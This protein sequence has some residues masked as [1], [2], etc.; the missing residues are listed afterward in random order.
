MADRPDQEKGPQLVA[1]PATVPTEDRGKYSIEMY[2]DSKRSSLAH[3]VNACVVSIMRH[4]G[5]LGELGGE[6][7]FLCQGTD[8]FEEMIDKEGRTLITRQRVGKLSGCGK[9]IPPE[10]VDGPLAVCPHCERVWERGKLADV[11]A[12]KSTPQALAEF[13]ADIYRRGCNSDA[14]L[15]IYYNPG[16]PRL[17]AMAGGAEFD[18]HR[19]SRKPAIYPQGHIRN[20]LL[21]GADIVKRVRAFITG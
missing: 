8:D 18:A 2:F 5:D 9:L 7:M 14:D 11:L 17:S 15:M 12:Y 19:M 3:S 10:A 16:D 20:D 6:M 21:A 13:V 1:R 4:R